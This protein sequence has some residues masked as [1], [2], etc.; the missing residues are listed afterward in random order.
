MHI[1]YVY[2][3]VETTLSHAI[4][5]SHHLYATFT[6]CYGKIYTNP[7]SVSLC[8]P[9]IKD[10]SEKLLHPC[11]L[12]PRTIFNDT[13]NIYSDPSLTNKIE[14]DESK[15]AITW[16]SD[17]N[18]FKNPSL[19]DIAKYKDDVNFWLMDEAYVKLLNMNDANGYGVENSHFIVW[20]KT[21]ALPEFRKKYAKINTEITLPIY[22]NITNNFPVDKF[23]G[24]KYFVIAEGSSFINEKTRSIGILYFFVGLFSLLVALCLVYNQLKHPRVIGY[25]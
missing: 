1:T 7:S 17:Y 8:Y 4:L 5:S 16:F 25:I 21:A 6:I 15:A 23:N 19:E 12:V 20:V 13:F 18:K 22:V 10:K 2:I 11:G 24:K 3:N 14:I 9:L